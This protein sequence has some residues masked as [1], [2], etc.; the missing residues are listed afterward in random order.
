MGITAKK[1]QK[2]QNMKKIILIFIFSL[3][4]ASLINAQT[5]GIMTVSFTTK[6]VPTVT[7][8]GYESGPGPGQ[9]R[10]GH[11]GSRSYAPQNILAVWV[12]DNSG[13][14]VKTLIVNADRY[15]TYLTS[16]KNSTASSGST[17]NSVDAITG[18]TN[19]NHGTRTCIWDGTDYKG[20]L[21]ADGTY[22]VCMELTESNATG[23]YTS[24]TIS[25][26]KREEVLKPADKLSFT[27]ISLKWEPGT[28]AITKN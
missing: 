11:G 15:K 19:R 2:R 25:K 28:S 21:V 18:A 10:G 9:M 7:G 26:G 22:K 14:F 4:T 17:F 12:E 3:V 5:K 16:W 27:S 23:H 8:N 20:K 13:K 1:N 6:S 24:F